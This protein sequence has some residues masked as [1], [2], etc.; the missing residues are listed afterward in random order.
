MDVLAQRFETDRPHLEAVAYRMLGSRTEADDAVQEAWLR[1]ARNGAD[2]VDNLL[3]GYDG[4]AGG[5]A[6]PGRRG[7]GAATST[8]RRPRR[9]WP[10]PSGRRCSSSR[11]LARRASRSSCDLP[12]PF[13]DR[14]IVGRSPPRPGAVAG[15]GGEVQEADDEVRSG[16][17]AGGGRERVRRV[18][19]GLAALALLD[20]DA[21]ARADAAA[22]VAGAEAEVR[23]AAAVATT[24]AG[25][26]K[27]ARLALLDGAPGLVWTHRGEPR[28]VFAWMSKTLAPE[29]SVTESAVMMEPSLMNALRPS[30][31]LPPSSLT[32]RCP[33][34]FETELNLALVRA[35]KF[36]VAPTQ[37]P[38][39]HA[40]MIVQA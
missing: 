32:A 12:V 17:G 19:R 29:P 13:E 8:R 38:A 4:R 26:A 31:A 15:R 18:A 5:H 30:F 28:M 21:T 27:A 34:A 10:I 3:A 20:P 25:R 7:A 2:G 9:C 22:V 16:E 36:G 39:A 1:L 6:A 24:F 37:T 11:T 40:S 14:A 23:G 33:I 35:R